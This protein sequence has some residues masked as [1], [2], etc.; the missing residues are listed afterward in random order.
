MY[1]LGA[2]KRNCYCERELSLPF[3]HK[4][5]RGNGDLAE[6]EHHDEHRF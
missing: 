3:T 4:A 5:V 6:M 1:C 2:D